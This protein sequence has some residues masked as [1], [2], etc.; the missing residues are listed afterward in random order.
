MAKKKEKIAVPL[1]IQGRSVTGTG[2]IKD[3]ILHILENAVKN[4]GIN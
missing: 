4:S 2:S 3:I 1:I